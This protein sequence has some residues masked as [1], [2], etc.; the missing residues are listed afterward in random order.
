[1]RLFWIL[2][3]TLLAAGV[4][5]LLVLPEDMKVK[6]LVGWEPGELVEPSSAPKDDARVPGA[7]S[8][9]PAVAAAGAGSGAPEL[10]PILAD[11]LPFDTQCGLFLTP[12]GSRDVIF[13]MPDAGAE[14]PSAMAA[15]NVAGTLVVMRRA[16]A[17][18]LPFGRG[19]FERQLFR[20]E[21]GTVTVVARVDPGAPGAAQRVTIDSGEL[22]VM[23]A[24]RST[25]K[26]PVAGAAGC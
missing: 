4:A 8:E 15:I 10:Q 13:M 14:Q 24:G 21:D 2:M 23:M 20:N 17:E 22:T 6:D 25:L 9:A 5:A 1:M 16:E 19:A 7:A 26:V 11:Q 12:P 3:V 18:G